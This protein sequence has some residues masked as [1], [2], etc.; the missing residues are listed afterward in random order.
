MV[1]F[2]EGLSLTPVFAA[3][4]RRSSV[5]RDALRPLTPPPTPAFA[6][7]CRAQTLF[8]D[9]S[10]FAADIMILFSILFT[11]HTTFA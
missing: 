1:P 4:I 3:T 9:I 10:A 2:Y 8:S 6:V 7:C 11:A 5:P